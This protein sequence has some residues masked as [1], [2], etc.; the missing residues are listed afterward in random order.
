V[1]VDTLNSRLNMSRSRGLNAARLWFSMSVGLSI[2]AAALAGCSAPQPLAPEKVA[3]LRAEPGPDWLQQLKVT[4]TKAKR[5]M[6]ITRTVKRA[7]VGYDGARIALVSEVLS[8]IRRGQLQRD[9]LLPLAE[10][11]L[12]Q[13]E[14]GLP[15][16][17]VG[18]NELHAVLDETERARLVELL[19]GEQDRTPEEREKE[20]QERIQR[21]LDLSAGQKAELF[22]ALLALTL[23]HWGLVRDLERGVKEAKASFLSDAF[24]A[25]TLSLVS[26]RKPME[27]LTALYEGLE[28]AL[29]VLTPAQRQTLA[30]Y[31]ETRLR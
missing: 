7:W 22:P 30:A 10:E 26:S 31:L 18:L 5:I 16:L 25:R 20:R 12:R 14:R 6:S 23:R 24:D 11:M 15:V 4:E 2:L 19:D 3:A 29:P 13:F 27:I 1:G 28:I 17:L 9:A 21:V 8:Q